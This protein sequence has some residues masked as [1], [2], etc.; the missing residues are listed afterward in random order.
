MSTSGTY[1]VTV[2]NANG[3]TATASR[4]LTVNLSATASIT[5]VS[6]ICGS[7]T[8]TFTAT[9]GGTYTWS[10]GASTTSITVGTAG[11]YTVTVANAVGCTA[12][13]SRTFTIGQ[14]PNATISGPS[15][16][17]SGQTATTVASGGSGGTYLWSIRS[18]CCRPVSGVP[19][20]IYT[21]TVTNSSGCSGTAAHTLTV[22]PTPTANISGVL[23]ICTGQTTS[24]TASGGDTYLWNTSETTP[25]ITVSTPGTYTVTVTNGGVCTATKQVIVEAGDC[26]NIECECCI[27]CTR[28]TCQY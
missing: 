6:N 15:T 22:I 27:L 7:G 1:T 12:T 21:V 26:H 20:G 2:T 5:G 19:A 25:S 8:S 9:G 28:C 23:S 3:C 11:T 14:F 4:S 13:A 17:C 16:I 24:L 18:R 10:N